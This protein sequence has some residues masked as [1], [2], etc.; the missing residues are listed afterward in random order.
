MSNSKG[1]INVKVSYDFTCQACGKAS[2]RYLQTTLVN[3]KD[4][5][6]LDVQ[7]IG[8]AVPS[9]SLMCEACIWSGRA[10][11]FAAEV[12]AQPKTVFVTLECGCTVKAGDEHL[13]CFPA[14]DSESA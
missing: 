7:S 12:K 2:A 8:L 3:G 14:D 1:T 5:P 11:K 13:T 4:G 9:G 6:R 10:N